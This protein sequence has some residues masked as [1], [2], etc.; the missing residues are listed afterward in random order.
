M[1]PCVQ[2]IA[3]TGFG[4][5]AGKVESLSGSFAGEEVKGLALEHVEAIE[6]AGPVDLGVDGIELFL[7]GEALVEDTAAAW[8]I[9]SNVGHLECWRTWV[10]HDGER[11]IAFAQESGACDGEIVVANHGIDADIIGQVAVGVKPQAV[12][13]RH[14]VWIN[15]F[16]LVVGI[17]VA[18]EHL[19]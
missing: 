15:R 5:F 11:L 3:F 4:A 13:N 14:E 6:K 1:A 16:E 17:F 10:A 9:Q 2:A 18:A 8:F 19:E 12:C 7:E